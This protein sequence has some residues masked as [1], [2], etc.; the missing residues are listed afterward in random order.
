MEGQLG[1]FSYSLSPTDQDNIIIMTLV[2]YN[3]EPRN[4]SVL[5]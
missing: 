3:K 4:Y 5:K 1:H 2:S